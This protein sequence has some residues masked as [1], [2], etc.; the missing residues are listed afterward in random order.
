MGDEP[1]LAANRRRPGNPNGAEHLKDF[2]FQKGRS[3]NPTGRPKS[4][5]G[6]A[7]L[8]RLKEN[9]HQKLKLVVEGILGSAEKGDAKA[10]SA[11]FDRIDGKPTQPIEADVNLNISLAEAVAR[12]RDRLN[13]PDER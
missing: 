6:K 9:D 12:I 2:R 3:G 8:H 10:F 7:L 1:K 4:L 13:D 11:I 5:I